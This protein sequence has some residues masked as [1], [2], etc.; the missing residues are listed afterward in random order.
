[1]KVCIVADV[2][3]KPN[4][5]TTLACLNLINYLTSEGHEVRVLCGDEYRRDDDGFFVVQN[6]SFGTVIDD[7]LKKNGVALAKP[8]AETVERALDGVDI[9]HAMV[10]F[11][12][13][14]LALKTCQKNNIPV[15]A[16]F[17]CQAENISSH[18]NLMDAEALNDAIYHRFYNHFY[19]YVDGIH[20]PTEF[21]KNVFETS[22]GRPTPGYVISN[23][24]NDIFRKKD[25]ARHEYQI[26][27]SGRY[28]KEK[29]H[30]TLLDAVSKSR[31]R[32]RIKVVLAGTGPREKQIRRYGA[33]LGINMVMRFYPRDE[34]VDVINESTLYVHPAKVEIEAI[35]CLEAISCGL[36]PVISDSKKSATG[37]FA[38]DE[39]NLF[40]CGDSDDLAG[41]I[42]YWF[43]NP[44]ERENCSKRYLGFTKQFAQSECMAKMVEM[45]E[46]V[47]AKHETKDV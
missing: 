17:H 14:S 31:Y 47:I 3:G 1:M 10:P 16:G 43:D 7:Y 26:L 32:D 33:K 40:K 44:E 8:D 25:V 19:K 15:C 9:C 5:G 23:G 37:A 46:E 30:K 45:F 41:K 22:I 2:L 27:F 21:I 24:V 6:R 28:S 18:L 29:S 4:N 11:A 38:L 34:L 36:V 13:S 35:S 39:R 12:L 20:Y 42:D